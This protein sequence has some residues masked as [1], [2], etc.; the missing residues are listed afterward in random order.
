MAW[1]PQSP[2]RLSPTVELRLEIYAIVISLSTSMPA[3][4]AVQAGPEPSFKGTDFQGWDE[5]DVLTRLTSRLDST[6]TA[7]LRPRVHQHD[8]ALD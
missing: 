6:W 5:L 1:Q 7:R 2:G 3:A 4:L 8:R